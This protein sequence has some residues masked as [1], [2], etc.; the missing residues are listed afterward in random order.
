M[1]FIL[2]DETKIVL[3]KSDNG[4]EMIAELFSKDGE[5][6]ERSRFDIEDLYWK[7]F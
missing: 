2:K 1:E 4:K 5:F 3:K 6:L 7:F